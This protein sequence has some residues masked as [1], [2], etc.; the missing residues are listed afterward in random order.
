M[1][2]DDEETG[3]KSTLEEMEELRRKEVL[4]PLKTYIRY[5]SHIGTN[6]KTKDMERFIFRRKGGV[7]LI[8]VLKT[9][10]RMQLAA[11][12]LA[13]YQP[14]EVALIGFR[15]YAQKPIIHAA[16]WTGFRPYPGRFIP[17]TLTNPELPTYMDPEIIVVSDPVKERQ[18]LKEATL[19]GVPVIALCDTNNVLSNIDFAIPVNNKGR[20]SLALVY[21]LL[22]TQILRERG[23]LEED[24]T[25]KETPEDFMVMLS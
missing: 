18:A 25:I 16:K 10:E 3:E 14:D 24:Q 17:G 13:N 1:S 21:W 5:G 22:T 4:V 11:K 6:K 2:F 12:I 7:Y 15:L 20:K 23:E 9:D 8:N 19:M